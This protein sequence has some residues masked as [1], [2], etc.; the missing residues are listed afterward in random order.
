MRRGPSPTSATPRYRKAIK[1]TRTEGLAPL[2]G[3]AGTDRPHAALCCGSQQ[4]G[5]CQAAD[6]RAEPPQGEG[7]PP[8][9]RKCDA[10]LGLRGRTSG[11]ADA[12]YPQLSAHPPGMGGKGQ[13]PND[14]G[15]S[16]E[17][18]KKRLDSPATLEQKGSTKLIVNRVIKYW[19]WQ[20]VEEE[21]GAMNS[22][23]PMSRR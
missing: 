6:Q 8:A 20:L 12:C 14:G 7:E 3:G 15:S 23:A 18:V 9:L 4:Q 10:W 13:D 5:S 19:K 2:T 16:T 21:D 22:L 17:K 11:C 1:S